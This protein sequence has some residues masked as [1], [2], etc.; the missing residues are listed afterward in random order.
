VGLLADSL[1]FVGRNCEVFLGFD[2]ASFE[3]ESPLGK[4]LKLLL[5]GGE[6]V[7]ISEAEREVTPL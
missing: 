7:F 6:Q 2:G 5:V 3:V 1:H 4:S